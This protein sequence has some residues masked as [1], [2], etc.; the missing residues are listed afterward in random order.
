MFS[1]FL[2]CFFGVLVGA[3]F[4]NVD[5]K[6]PTSW[7]PTSWKLETLNS[8]INTVGNVGNAAC[9]ACGIDL[10]SSHCKV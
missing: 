7:E 4:A 8:M 6:N 9:G 1:L 3:A 10:K 5:Y 2:A